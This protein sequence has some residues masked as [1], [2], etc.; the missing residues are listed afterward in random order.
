MGFMTGYDFVIEIIWILACIIV[1]NMG[2]SLHGFS[3]NELGPTY[4]ILK[5][6]I[7]IFTRKIVIITINILK[8]S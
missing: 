2:A 5:P 4:L 1:S 3:R 8:P 7:L 6:D